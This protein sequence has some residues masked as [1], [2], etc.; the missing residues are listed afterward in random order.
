MMWIF[1]HPIQKPGR[2]LRKTKTKTNAE[3]PPWAG[4]V[5]EP[6]KEEAREDTIGIRD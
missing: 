5:E 2:Q 1:E 4:I 3:K 6:T